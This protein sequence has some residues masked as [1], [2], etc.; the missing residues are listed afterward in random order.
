MEVMDLHESLCHA[1]L[2]S[3]KEG[4]LRQELRSCI[5]VSQEII[6]L[7]RNFLGEHVISSNVRGTRPVFIVVL[8]RDGDDTTRPVQKG[9]SCCGILRAIHFYIYIRMKLGVI[10]IR[11]CLAK[12]I[13]LTITRTPTS[14]NAL[15]AL[16]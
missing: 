5:E 1:S 14:K 3:C 4:S 7:R 15:G 8:S 9:L 11:L 10:K 6:R 16:E 2:Q 12:G 13:L